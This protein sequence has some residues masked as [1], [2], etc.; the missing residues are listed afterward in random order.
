MLPASKATFDVS[1]RPELAAA[2]GGPLPARP[3]GGR[4]RDFPLFNNG[5]FASRHDL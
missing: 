3:R 1:P 2:V 5:G 4:G